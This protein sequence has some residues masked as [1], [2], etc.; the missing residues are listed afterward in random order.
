MSDLKLEKNLKRGNRGKKVKLIQEW[1]YIHGF[2]LV[3]DGIFG[4]AT[5]YAVR[6]F[7]KRKNLEIDGIVGPITFAALIYPIKEVLKPIDPGNRTARQLVVTY[8]RQHLKQSP[9]EV[10]GENKGPWVRLYM[11]ENEGDHWPWCAGFI[12]FILEQTY[13]TL[14]MPLPIETSFSCDLLA[15]SAMNNGCFLEENDSAL[16]SKLKPGAIFLSQRSSNDWNHTGIVI[17]VDDEVFHTIEGNTPGK[18]GYQGDGV[19]S[20]VRWY[21]DKDFI[22]I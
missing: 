3:I 16:Q 12:S 5:D 21:N 18:A 10:G 7:Q 20:L 13:D 2:Q 19:C 11:K 17:K 8:A 9:V 15:T 6:K 1:L 4:P 14:Q 22:C